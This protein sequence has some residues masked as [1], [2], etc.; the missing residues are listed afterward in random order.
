MSA[1][2]PLPLNKSIR[3]EIF[4]A[5]GKLPVLRHKLKNAVFSDSSGSQNSFSVSLQSASGPGALLFS[6]PRP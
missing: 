5:S 1:I 6:I 4:Q 2:S 3:L